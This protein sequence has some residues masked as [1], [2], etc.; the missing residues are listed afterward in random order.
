MPKPAEPFVTLFTK[1]EPFWNFVEL[2]K[3]FYQHPN[4][5]LQ[6]FIPAMLSIY[7]ELSHFDKEYS[8]RK[9]K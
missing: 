3:M 7:S 8:W 6:A 1:G 9:L 4:W 5:N 2:S